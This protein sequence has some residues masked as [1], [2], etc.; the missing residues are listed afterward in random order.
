MSGLLELLDSQTGKQLIGGIAGQTGHSEEK[1]ANVLSMAMPL[2]M[3]AMKKNAST[4]QGAERL[5]NAINSKHNGSIL[6]NLGA[7]S[8]EVL[9]NL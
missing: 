7:C 3:G 6:D 2:L 9:I 1:T 8:T 5:M 4:P